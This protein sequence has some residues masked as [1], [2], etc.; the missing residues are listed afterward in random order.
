MSHSR[1]VNLS[2]VEATVIV[3]SNRVLSGEKPDRGGPR[4]V[5]RLSA[6]GVGHVEIR[7][8]TEDRSAIDEALGEALD[9]GRRLVIVAGCS[10]FGVG[11]EA[12]EAVR[13]VIA[14]E[15]EGIAEQ[16]RAHGLTSTPLAALSREVVGVTSRDR[17]G[18]L[19]ISSPGSVS[20]IDDTLD[21]VVPL[22]GQIYSQLGER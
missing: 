10:G 5:E 16:I 20:G 15:I 6:E 3:A 14:V 1:H 13:A 9:L 19:V 21:V 11:N 17:G 18:A 7:T 8:V 2:Q 22:L 12:P 4:C